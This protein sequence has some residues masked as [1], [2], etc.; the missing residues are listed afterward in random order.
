MNYF[1]SCLHCLPEGR[2]SP[3]RLALAARRLGYG[4]IIICNHTGFENLFRP[5]AA[6][7]VKGIKVIFGAE[8]M[9][10]NP[11]IL[12]SR[13][14][15]ARAKFP[16]VTVHGG[17]EEMNKAA[18]EDQDVDVLVHPEE[19]RRALSVT[20]ARAASHNQVAIGFDLGPLIRL[21][22]AAR[23]RWLQVVEKNLDLARK[24]DLSMTI[25]TGPRSHL[26]LRAP[27]DL[28]ALA[29]VAGFESSEADEA[30][31]LPGMIYELN[32]RAWAGPGVEII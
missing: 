1:E 24:F 3:S 28:M 8:V 29:E 32:R 5:E 25:T 15:S 4:G 30:L 20:A 22:G 2:D 27:R 23:S 19:G 10:A 14:A 31:R 13:V 16:F 11:K 6:L 26:D 12:R 18:C 21:R 17:S 9:A 7:D